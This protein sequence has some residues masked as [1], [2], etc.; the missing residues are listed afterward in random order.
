MLRELA[1]IF[2][3]ESRES[4]LPFRYGG[5]EFVFILPNSDLECGMQYAEK[6]RQA[7]ANHNFSV[8][9]KK[10]ASFGVAQLQNCETI[11]ELI[12]RADTALYNSKQT[13]RNRT[14]M[15]H[16]KEI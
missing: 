11:Q 12:E 1:D 3:R 9:G 16:A 13:G 8:I 14:T 5:E 7:I 6:L 15:S 2:R 10:T 4:D